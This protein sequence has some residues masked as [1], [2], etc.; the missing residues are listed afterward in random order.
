MGVAQSSRTM[1]VLCTI[2]N[3]CIWT[4]DITLFRVQ[5]KPKFQLATILIGC[6]LV[7]APMSFIRNQEVVHASTCSLSLTEPSL[8]TI[9]SGTAAAATA[10]EQFVITTAI[11]TCV[12][13]DKPFVAI[14]EVRNSDS[15]TEYLQWQA[16]TQGSN[17]RVEVGVPWVPTHGDAYEVRVFLISDFDHPLILS[18]VKTSDVTIEALDRSVVVIPYDANGRST[19]QPVLLKVVVGMN[20][21]VRWVNEDTKSHRLAGTVVSHDSVL[22][23][24]VEFEGPVFLYSADWVEHTFIQEGFF[25]YNDPDNPEDYGLV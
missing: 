24:A 12:D 1:D 8:K 14:A 5:D 7:V 6:T 11:T 21:T 16:G 4:N 19:F 18:G 23:R 9:Y 22:T 2:L 15:V 10:G 3:R 25:A 13:E 20:N 17:E